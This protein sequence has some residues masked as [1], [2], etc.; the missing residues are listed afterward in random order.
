MQLFYKKS[1]FAA[2]A[3]RTLQL[4]LGGLVLASAA[5]QAAPDA[6][7]PTVPS[8]DLNRYLGTWYEIA[9][10]PNR[11][12]R[13]CVSDTQAHYSLDEGTV[14]VRNR[15]RTADGSIEEA[16]G[17]A[18]VVADS[19]NAKLRVSFF[20]PFYGNYWILA[21][22]EA[23][24]EVLVGEPGREYGWILARQPDLPEAR[25]QALLERANA[26]GFPAQRFQRVPHGRPLEVAGAP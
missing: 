17:R 19:G 22:D 9:L 15:C 14:R 21:L 2:G 26:L 1:L 5:A 20:W 18:K 24:S 10:L 25:I 3:R 4:I 23:Y 6:P 12:E 11:F 8:V 7:L 16:K 13:R